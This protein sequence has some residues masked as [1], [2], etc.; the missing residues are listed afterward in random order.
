MTQSCLVQQEK[1]QR[2]LAVSQLLGRRLSKTDMQHALRICDEEMTTDHESGID[3]FCQRL[4]TSIPTVRLGKQTRLL[5][6]HK[7]QQPAGF[8]EPASDHEVTCLLPAN[9]DQSEGRSWTEQ[10]EQLGERRRRPRK[11]TQIFGSYYQVE[12]SGDMVV[13]NLSQEGARLKIL[14][15]HDLK[16]GETL[17]LE[18]SLDDAYRTVIHATGCIRWTLY[19][20]IGVEFLGAL[21]LPQVF[22]DYLQS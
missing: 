1:V 18:F 6:L 19:E 8:L 4:T 14:N 22:V 20:S 5:F 11:T 10:D 7:L 2:R 12:Q 16:K 13:E 15:P 17:R 9:T 21:G 3:E